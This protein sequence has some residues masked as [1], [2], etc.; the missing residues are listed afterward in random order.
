MIGRPCDL[1]D[2]AFHAQ[3]AECMPL[4]QLLRSQHGGAD[5]EKGLMFLVNSCLSPVFSQTS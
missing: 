2:L 1:T 4:L 3:F 5:K